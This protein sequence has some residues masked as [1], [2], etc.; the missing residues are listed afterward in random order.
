MKPL[1]FFPRR[2]GRLTGSRKSALD[3]A[4]GRLVLVSAFFALAY[5]L[6]AARVFDLSVIQGALHQ[7]ETDT[8]GEAPAT[9]RA[10]ITDRNGVLLATSF[11]H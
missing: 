3:L 6:V 2:T 4:R 7:G 10:D 11:A 9:S 1:P 8:G 5:M